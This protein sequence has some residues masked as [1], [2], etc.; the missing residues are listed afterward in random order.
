MSKSFEQLGCSKINIGLAIT[1]KREDGYHDIDSIF[2]SIRLSDSIY[3]AKHHSVVFSGGAP[4]LPEY[5]QKLVTYGEENL[6][7]KALRA[8]QEYTGCK[9][10]AAIH[11]LKRVPIQAGLGGGSADAAAMLVGLNRFWDLRLT[12]EELLQ[13]GATLGSDVPFLLQGGTAR[14]TGRGEILTY[15]KS[16]DPHWLLLVKPKVSVSTAAAYGRFTNKS[17]AT[18]QTIDTVQ[19]HLENNDLKSAFLTSA[20]TFE[21]LLFPDHEELVICKEFFTSRGYPTIM[22][23]SGPTM[24]VL[25]DKPMEALQLQEEIKAAGHDWLSLITK[26]CTQEDLP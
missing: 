18:K 4:E 9:A 25:L 8:V 21:E 13:I 3:F 16:P 14:G 20:N 12:Q 15:G 11:L 24:V 5:M 17:V 19:Q 10:G 1:G 26:T 7:L 6:A 22:T 2:Q 23:G